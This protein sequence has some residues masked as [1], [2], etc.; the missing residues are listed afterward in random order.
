MANKEP[1]YN[2]SDWRALEFLYTD[3]YSERVSRAKKVKLLPHESEIDMFNVIW[4]GT[5]DLVRSIGSNF[6]GQVSQPVRDLLSGFSGPSLIT[7]S[8]TL[9]DSATR[10]GKKED[11]NKDQD[12]IAGSMKQLTYQ[13]VSKLAQSDTP[14]LSQD[15]IR[16]AIIENPD[17]SSW[18]RQFLSIR[19]MKNLPAEA[20]KSM[21][22]SLATAIGEKLE[23]QS[24]V[25]VGDED[26][27]KSA[28]P[29]SLIKVSTVK[30]LAQLLNEADFI[31]P[32]SAVE[33][34]IELFKSTTHIDVRLASLDSLLSTLNAIAG[35]SGEKWKSNPMVEKI[36]STLDSVISIAGN[37]NER[38][39]VG[40]MDWAEVEEKVTIPAVSTGSDIPPL[41][42]MIINVTIGERF[43]NLR[44]LQGELFSR[45]VLPTLH[46]S[47]EQH[48]RW[49]SL[50]LAK[51]RSALN[52]DILP[53]VPIKPRIWQSM[54]KLQGHLLPSR[55]IHEYN[56]YLLLQLKTP[57]DI[58]DFNKALQS[59]V[60]LRNDPNVTHWL[61]IFGK[62]DYSR[63]WHGEIHSLLNLM[64]API[65]KASPMADL[66]GAVVDQASVLLDDYEDRMGEWSHLVTG[67]GPARINRPSL[68]T[69]DKND[70]DENMEKAW[71]YWREAT[72]ALSQRLITL[73][74][75]KT[76]SSA[77][78]DNAHSMLPSTFPLRLWCLPYPDPLAVRRDEDFRHLATVLDR[79]LS[80]YLQSDEG[81]TLLWTTLVDETYTTLTSMYTTITTLLSVTVHVG[82]LDLDPDQTAVVAVQLI[83]VKVAL[84]LVNL[85][86]K[87]S[88]AFRKPRLEKDLTPE[89]AA[90]GELVKRLRAVMD[91]WGRRGAP[92]EQ[93]Q[94]RD[95]AMRWKGVDNTTSL[96]HSAMRFQRVD[97]QVAQVSNIAGREEREEREKASAVSLLLRRVLVENPPD[98]ADAE[99]RRLPFQPRSYRDFMLFER[100]YYGA[101]VGMTSLYRPLVN[102]LGSLFSMITGIDFPPFKPHALW[103]EQ[104]IFY[105]SNHLAFYSDGA[106]ITYPSYCRYLDVE[107][108][109]G[110]VLGKPLYNAS[111]DE[112]T[113]AIAGF[114]V[115]NDF[116]VRNTQMEEMAS[117]LFDSNS[118]G[119]PVVAPY[120]GFG[121]QHSKAF[122]N[123]IS[124]TVVSADEVLH[125]INHLS[126]RITV[127]NVVVKEP[128]VD[129]WQFTLGQVSRSLI[130]S[131][132]LDI[133]KAKAQGSADIS[134]PGL[135]PIL[136]ILTELYARHSH[137]C[138]R[139]PACI[140]AS[141]LAAVHF[142]RALAS[143][144]A[145][146]QLHVGD[147]VKLEIDGIGSVTNTIVPETS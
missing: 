9:L 125:R 18:H 77:G 52:V 130:A 127:N 94:F 88:A 8:E 43:P 76:A 62:P 21:L 82:D 141:F 99:K 20:A 132:I 51:H 117:N 39:P 129:N 19:Y 118:D 138:Q 29:K 97:G 17:A 83:K 104:P 68:P 90:V 119:W 13:V 7:A 142:H 63:P 103:Y 56:Q 113:A 67:L 79:S 144:D 96:L 11:R 110:V 33:I 57:V 102:R 124:S 65:E 26:P 23:E 128:K 133:S 74:E 126:G 114:C 140:Q 12:Y 92:G 44:K 34:L 69:Q 25:K 123:S 64:V 135:G 89:R 98:D 78:Q 134:C 115:F 54:L 91:R 87:N 93:T 40:A 53:R 100:H 139:A 85:L 108:E 121:P 10:W 49:F 24:Y 120:S 41:F 14:M 5:A 73:I 111:P 2:S 3:V 16:R 101:A 58:K 45:L 143:N 146:F 61:S 59:D 30:Y 28:P 122:A 60:T 6:L 66:M 70:Y 137:M 109:L 55:T 116:S 22:L 136:F 86:T 145:A 71:A 107:L 106:S 32:D 31:S 131:F 80:S 35:D 38:R 42:E 27:P 4:E 50:F 36:L 95:M 105:Q 75:Q 147:V 1:S 84:R 112:A 47:Q 46:H 81:D 15:L 48:H 37:V 72:L